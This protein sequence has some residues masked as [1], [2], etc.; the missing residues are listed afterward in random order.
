MIPYREKCAGIRFEDAIPA[1]SW[2]RMPAHR[3]AGGGTGTAGAHTNGNEAVH[4]RAARTLKD[5]AHVHES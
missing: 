5:E 4:A 2:G 3:R 1:L